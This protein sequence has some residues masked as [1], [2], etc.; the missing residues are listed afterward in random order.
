MTAFDMRK[1]SNNEPALAHP[2]QSQKGN[3]A[4]STK[5]Q[6]GATPCWPDLF[7]FFNLVPTARLEL[8]QLAPLPPQDSVSTNFTTSAK[9]AILTRFDWAVQRSLH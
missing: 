3:S 9:H 6:H 4:N 5:S 1:E 2:M 7:L 8:A